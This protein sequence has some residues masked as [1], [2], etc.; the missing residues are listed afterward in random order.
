MVVEEPELLD[1]LDDPPVL[2]L[3][4]LDDTVVPVLP[5]PD[6]TELPVGL[7]ELVEGMVYISWALDVP[8]DW[9]ARGPRTPPMSTA[10]LLMIARVKSSVAAAFRATWV[11]WIVISNA[12]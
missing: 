10:K 9:G 2:V 6:E 8:P 4:P 5:D 3:E 7:V 12:T 1:E 11:C